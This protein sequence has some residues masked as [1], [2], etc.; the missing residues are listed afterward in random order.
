M[1]GSE[2]EEVTP[3]IKSLSGIVPHISEKDEKEMY[4]H[5]LIGSNK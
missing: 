3:L 5:Y 2:E 1:E 4:T